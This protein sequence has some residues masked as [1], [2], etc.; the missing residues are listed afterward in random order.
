ML[1]HLCDDKRLSL[2]GQPE[3]LEDNMIYWH[4]EQK[5]RPTS[6]VRE[7]MA[8]EGIDEE[9]GKSIYLVRIGNGWCKSKVKIALRY[10]KS[11]RPD[12][13]RDGFVELIAEV[14]E[15][16]LLKMLW[17]KKMCELMA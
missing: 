4:A 3:Q 11:I 2:I 1:E 17:I 15:E 5:G 14:G 13:S 10:R 16:P 12:L 6:W 8:K 7:M 9:T